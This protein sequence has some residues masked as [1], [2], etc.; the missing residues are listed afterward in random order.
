MKVSTSNGCV[1]PDDILTYECTIV[2]D[3]GGI[4]LWMGDFFHC[5]SGRQEIQLLHSDFTNR[6][7]RE[8]YN[9]QICNDGNI[10]GRIVKAEN[11]SYTSQL[12]ATLTSD[13]VGKAINCSYDNGTVHRVGTLNITE[14]QVK[15]Q[16]HNITGW[17][18][19]I[20]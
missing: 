9:T 15:L 10:V 1:C 16:L 11:G 7:G 2:G 8:A 6:R 14:G 13:I 12:N 3:I 20:P 19:V 17:Y 5:P 18:E 4:T